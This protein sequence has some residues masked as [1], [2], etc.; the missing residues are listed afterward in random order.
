MA[1]K[2]T[3]YTTETAPD[4]TE[5]I[6]EI[7]TVMTETAPDGT[8]TVAEITTT[9]DA[10]DPTQVEGHI[11]LTETAPDGTETV[12]EITTSADGTVTVEENE[13]FVEEVIEAVFDVEIGDGAA[14]GAEISAQEA[15]AGAAL[16]FAES[17]S[18]FE[19]S[20]AGFPAGGEMFAPNALPTEMAETPGMTAPLVTEAPDSTFGFASAAVPAAATATADTPFD[21]SLGATDPEAMEQEAHAQAATEA[22]EAADE[23]I[24]SGDYAAAAEARETAENEAWEAGDDSMLGA[25]DAQDLTVAAEKQEEARHYEE[26]QAQFAQAGDYEAAREAAGNAAYATYEAD[27]TA[28]GAD[29]TGQADAEYANMDNAVWQEGL[30]EDDLENAAYHAEMGN[31]DA[32]EASLSS[33]AANQADADHYG[34]LGEHGGD[35]AVFDPSSAVAT[36]GTYESSFDATAAQ[37]DTGFSSGVDTSMSSVSDPGTDDI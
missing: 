35:I 4:G 30:A 23:F 14:G 1:N 28:G 17:D 8:E 37:V 2:D 7:N 16:G 31:L 21:S 27:S 15:G 6:S 5:I 24:A 19:T 18:V 12:T 29:H 20:G 11:T 13:S 10:D 22:Q 3:T 33:A 32:A 34:D 25:Y 26:Q 36:G 9:A